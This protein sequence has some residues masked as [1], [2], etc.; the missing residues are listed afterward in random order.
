LK[1]GYSFPESVSDIDVLALDANGGMADALDIQRLPGPDALDQLASEWEVLDKYTF[2]RTPFTSPAWIGLWWEHFRRR[3]GFFHDEF[4]CHV[5][6]DG[7]GT[8][9]AIAPLMRSYVPGLGP[10]AVRVV[11]FFGT[12]P[13]LTE[14]RGVI[15]RPEDH[16]KV[17]HA[18]VGHFVRRPG[19]WDVFR[20][21]G[22][23]HAVSAY[24]SLLSRCEF[25]PR[26]ERTD[27]IIELPRSWD[28]LKARVSAN[29]RKNLRKAYE[30]LE[31][32][33]FGFVL[34]VAERPDDVQ[35][36]LDR[37]LTLHAA[38]SE[39]AGMIDHPNRFATSRAR[40]FLVDY[41]HHLAARGQLRIF[42]LDIGGKIVASRLTFV[43][44]ADLYTYFAGYDPAWK[45]YSVMTI[46]VS[47]IIKWAVSHGMKRVNLS[48]GTD[49]SKLR[50]K[51]TE[52]VF[53][54]AVQIS[55]TV[56]GRAAFQVFK[57]YEGLSRLRGRLGV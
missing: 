27:Y 15:C 32:D 22:L 30:F 47:E 1:A 8:L 9:V 44:E 28:E 7:G 37:F 13:A 25:I 33:G 21:N 10:P 16:T 35:A 52:L 43:F 2:P 48:T 56:R 24:N 12:D 51:P 19:E 40:A 11:Q 20:W 18:L 41:L 23:H 14:L 54:D 42:E 6:R 31:R 17:I 53:R 55:P 46:L 3:R 38:R 39:A 57:A 4:F 29:M 5:I 36:A 26:Y 49:Q 34:R 50:W 45:Q